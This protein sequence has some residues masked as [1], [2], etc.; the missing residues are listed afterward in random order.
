MSLHAQL[1]PEALA[2]L[3]AQRRNSSISSVVIAFL[4]LMLMGLVLGF[5]LLPAIFKETP[6]IVTYAASSSEETDLEQ[7]KISTSTERR[8][9]S[10]ASAMA[11]VIAANTISAVAIPVPD[12][13]VSSPSVNFGDG[14]DFGSGWGAGGD[15]GGGGSFGTIPDIMKKRCSKADRLARLKETGGTPACEDAVVKALRWFKSSQSQD[16]SWAGGSAMTGLALLAYL[17]H[18]ETPLSEEFGESCLRAITSLVNLGMKNHGKL[19]DNPGAKQ[20]PYEHAIATYALAE[21]ATFCKEIKINVPNLQETAQKAG[22]FIIDNQHPSGGW[23]YSYNESGARGG[24]LSITAWQIQAL[25]ACKHTG[26]DFRNLPNCASRAMAYVEK[27]ASSAGGFGYT[28]ANAPAGTDYFTLTGAGV[29]S[30]QL[31]DRGSRSAARN[32]AKYIGKNTRFDYNSEFADLYG[33][34]YEAQAMMNRGGEQWRRYNSLFR[35]QLLKN[36]NAD[37]SWKTPGGGKTLRAVAPQYVQDV[38][39]RT[40]LCTLMLE[41]YYRFLPGTGAGVR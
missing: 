10:P 38:H 21:A 31:W 6:T 11:K 12:I 15:G 5:I 20:F 26:L 17:G 30:L 39:Y 16:G 4:T 8:P 37:G 3:E 32:G 9:A 22:Q 33:H 36:Q 29:L 18:C 34:Y 40:C 13:D 27:L 14:D 1:S 25:K 41:V 7:K 35:D 24:D 19:S 23:D 28:S 2:R